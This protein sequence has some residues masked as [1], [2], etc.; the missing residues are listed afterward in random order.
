MK[1]LTQQNVSGLG[2][3]TLR[4][5]GYGI[6]RV[7]HE[8]TTQVSETEKATV[9]TNFVLSFLLAEP[10]TTPENIAKLPFDSIATLVDIAVDTC[11]IREEFDKTPTDLAPQQRLYQAYVDSSEK[12][13]EAIRLTFSNLSEQFS[14]QQEELRNTLA[15]FGE[16]IAR[17]LE[18][19]KT[20]SQV[21]GSPLAQAGFWIPP[22][23][24]FEL[25][26]FLK[27][28]IGG[29]ESTPEKV[30]QAIAECFDA[31][32]FTCL[33]N[34]VNGWQGN[35]FARHELRENRVEINWYF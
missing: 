17:S 31:N 32:E 29:G 16:A 10:A 27:D 23:A 4:P 21:L 13:N 15:S 8:R 26:H 6:M 28:L 30:R 35:C 20:S 19:A 9:F 25:L 11:R 1:N 33:K 5:L 2:T 18:E 12:L 22:S 34:M 24:P 14:R 7:A 3:V